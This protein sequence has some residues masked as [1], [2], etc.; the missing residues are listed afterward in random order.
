MLTIK[1]TVTSE[2]EIKKSKFI[3]FAFSVFCDKDVKDCLTEIRKKYSD[4][5]HICYAYVLGGQEKCSDD[6]EPAGT[7]G[8]PLLDLI[9]NKKYTNLLLVVVRYFG[10]IKLGAGGL[11][12]AYITSGVS[13]LDMCTPVHLINGKCVTIRIP[14]ACATEMQNKLKDFPLINKT[15]CFESEVTVEGKIK[16]T[17][18]KILE[19]FLNNAQLLYIVSE[20]Y[21]EDD[22]GNNN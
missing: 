14:Y 19:E 16:D 12:R 15:T 10:G 5:R 6:G 22:D 1:N 13:A 7:A 8:K 21:L 4:A 3:S 9:K 20:T 17:N 2:Y 18:F 11:Y